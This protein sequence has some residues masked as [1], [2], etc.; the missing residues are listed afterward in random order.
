MTRVPDFHFLL[1]VFLPFKKQTR[2][3]NET[4]DTMGA[5]AELSTS[6]QLHVSVADGRRG[7]KRVKLYRFL[8]VYL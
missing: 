4:V 8:A 3:E 2:A 7:S 6:E 5:G 1:R